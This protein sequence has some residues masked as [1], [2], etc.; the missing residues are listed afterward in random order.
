MLS[1]A[2]TS[3]Y[4]YGKICKKIGLHNMLPKDILSQQPENSKIFADLFEAY[5]F[6]IYKDRN[7]DLEAVQAMFDSL[8][9]P[10]LDVYYKRIVCIELISGKRG[11]IYLATRNRCARARINKLANFRFRTIPSL[12]PK[13][14][15]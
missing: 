13:E 12:T 11:L 2:L 3:N 7:Y 6:A 5:Y 10:Y 14:A 8:I 1:C 15:L 4:F 9:T